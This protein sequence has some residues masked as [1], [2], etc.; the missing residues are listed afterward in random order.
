MVS[1]RFIIRRLLTMVPVLLLVSLVAFSIVQLLP[2]DPAMMMLGDQGARDVELYKAVRAELGLDKPIPIQYAEWLGRVLKG[3]FGTSVRSKQSVISDIATRLGPTIELSLL[4]LCY[5]LLIGI[6]VGVI[7]AAKPNS[8]GDNAG[9][10]FA[11]AGVAMPNFWLGILLIYTFALLLRWLPPSGYTPF[12]QNPVQNLTLMLLP[13]VTLGTGIGAVLM[14]QVRSA[15]LEVLQQEYITTARAKGLGE[16][17]VVMRHALMNSLIPVV[18]VIGL[19]IGRLLGGAVITETIFSV[20][21]VG[22]LPADSIFLRDFPVVQGVV[23]VLAIGVLLSNF[24]TD[25][26]YAQIDPRIR[27]G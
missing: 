9:S 1:Y 13:A 24:L 4:A 19:Q 25:L 27:F 16:R 6:P 20:P 26:I 5:A 2:G 10:L 11:L 21:G 3:D 7:S 23:L 12:M 8:W 15:L 22:R 17:I 18:T 14:R